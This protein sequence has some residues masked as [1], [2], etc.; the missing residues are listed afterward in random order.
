MVVVALTIASY[1]RLREAFEQR[2]VRK[3]Y[4]AVVKDRPQGD[5]GVIKRPLVEFTG[6]PASDRRERSGGRKL[7]L[8]RVSSS[9]KPAV[10]AWRLLS[11][12]PGA[13]LLECRPVTGRLHQVRAH[14]ASIGCPILGDEFY[15]GRGVESAAPRLALHAHRIVLPDPRA[16]PAGAPA[17]AEDAT[18]GAQP[19]TGGPM[20]DVR[21]PMPREFRRLLEQLR[22]KLDA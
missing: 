5:S 18:N 9:G 3:F 19:P 7:K 17:E 14:L 21:S 4:W 10:T 8:A 2:T 1:E 6:T 20:L 12:A 13:S 16:Q 22:L 15:A 11:T